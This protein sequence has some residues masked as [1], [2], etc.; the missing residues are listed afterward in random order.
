VAE[1]E[2][3]AAPLLWKGS[4]LVARVPSVELRIVIREYEVFDANEA[5]PGQGW[6]GE[7]AGT[8]RRLVYA[9]VIPLT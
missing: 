7:P 6:I 4:V 8:S 3:F 9:D 5:P 2:T 1:A